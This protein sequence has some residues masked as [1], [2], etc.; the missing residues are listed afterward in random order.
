[1][2]ILW[3]ELEGFK[4]FAEK[5][6]F[7]FQKNS[8]ISGE[9]GTG[10]SSIAEG[11]VFAFYGRTLDGRSKMI[12]DVVNLNHK[13]KDAVISVGFEDPET[14]EKR[15]LTR[16]KNIKRGTEISLD[17]EMV[18]QDSLDGMFGSGDVFLSVFSNPFFMGLEDGEKRS[19]L[20]SIS[21]SV[22]YEEIFAQKADINLIEKHDI[23]IYDQKA[24]KKVKKQIDELKEKI[25]ASITEVE[26]LKK[27]NIEIQDQELIEVLENEEKEFQIKMKQAQ[28]IEN[29]KI[30]LKQKIENAEFIKNQISNLEQQLI[31]LQSKGQKL[32]SFEDPDSIRQ[33]ENKV[34]S[35]QDG[36]IQNLL[37]QKVSPSTFPSLLNENAAG[38]HC[39]TCYQEISKEH[40]ASVN[41]E[42][43]SKIQ[44][45]EQNNAAIDLVIEQIKKESAVALLD[46]EKRSKKS[47]ETQN[48]INQ[49]NNEITNLQSKIEQLKNNLYI[50]AS[51]D[52]KILNFDK[53][54][55][56][57]QECAKVVAYNQ[58]AREKNAV[59]KKEIE[60]KNENLERIFQLDEG[61]QNSSI[62]MK[63]LQLIANAI[64]PSFLQK[65]AIEQKMEQIKAHLKNV[66]I[67]LYKQQKNGEWKEVFEIFWHHKPYRRLSSSEKLK[68]GVEISNMINKVSK[69]K[70]PIFVDNTEMI[71]KFEINPEIDTQIILAK[72]ESG[73]EVCV[74]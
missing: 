44:Q 73:K 53:F 2:K 48:S 58:N 21:E 55:I 32:P 46:L 1:M 74:N 29:R 50:P 28:D 54:E 69:N 64:N 31:E 34:R 51:E 12:D 65:K 8:I 3:V 33:F 15:I 14:F 47:Q 43:S 40:I 68:C 35:E 59:S 13:D 57:A 63:E 16:T 67:E 62:L 20:E 26:I 41:Q 24:Y 18:T 19:I 38:S 52:K 11:V 39:S 6:K 45:F 23:Q 7:D 36:K 27:Q 37:G 56:I 4:G 61:L 66:S 30:A 5:T 22:D 42:I 17:G 25:D 71:S 72:V 9:N 49:L 10:K 70:Y 60:R